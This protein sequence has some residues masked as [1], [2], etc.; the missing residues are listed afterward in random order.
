MTRFTGSEYLY[1]FDDQPEE[2]YDL[3]SD[4]LERTNLAP[5]RPDDVLRL[6]AETLEWRAAM[7]ALYD[8]HI[9]GK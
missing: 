4:P 3:S 1:F 5:G 6:R 7:L 2:L 9:A 8:E